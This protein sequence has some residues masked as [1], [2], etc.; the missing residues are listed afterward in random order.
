MV[1]LQQAI[2]RLGMR[3]IS[4]I[5][6]AASIN[7]SLFNAPGYESHIASELKYALATA[8]WAKEIARASRRN[9]EAA[10]I[11][12]LLH[13]IGRPVAV[14][15]IV[16]TSKELNIT[17]TPEELIGLERQFQRQFGINVVEQWDMPNSVVNAVRFFDDYKQPHDSTMVT[18]I[19]VA[20]AKFVSHFMCEP[21]VMVCLTLDELKAQTVLGDLD[22]YPDDVE[23]LTAKEPIVVAAMEAMSV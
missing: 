2:A 21:G 19:V 12:G 9:V 4:E 23:A 13:D 10:F 7:S 1:S 16:K 22:L 17:L 14:Q 11:A 20:G 6:L 15:A 18:M 3:L 5:A 8:L